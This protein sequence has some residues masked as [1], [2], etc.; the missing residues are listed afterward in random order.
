M[1]SNFIGWIFALLVI[2]PL[3]AQFQEQAERAKLPMEIV[4]HSQACLVTLG[5]HL[6]ERATSD[7]GWAAVTVVNLAI[8]TTTLAELLG[9][10]DR[11]CAALSAS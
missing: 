7:Y 5:P 2:D 6:V 10:A 8:G 1:I 9:S 3:Q 11:Q 4:R